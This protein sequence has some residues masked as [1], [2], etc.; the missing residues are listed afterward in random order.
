MDIRSRQ[1]KT[2]L[3]ATLAVL[4]TAV[5]LVAAGCTS[6]DGGSALSWHIESVDTAG[7][8][9]YGTSIALNAN[10]YPHISYYDWTNGDL[11]YTRYGE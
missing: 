10:G 6:P 4:G 5:L 9:P 8:V 7:D 3:T 11:K 2:L 1:S